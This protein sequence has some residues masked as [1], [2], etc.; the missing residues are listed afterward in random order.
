M[1]PWSTVPGLKLFQ[2]DAEHFKKLP[3]H[4]DKFKESTRLFRKRGQ[5]KVQE[6]EEET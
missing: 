3:M 4:K 6:D 5:G 1:P 2:D